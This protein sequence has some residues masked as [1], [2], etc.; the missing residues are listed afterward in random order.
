[1]VERQIKY[2]RVLMKVNI[3]IVFA[4][5]IIALIAILAT[6]IPFVTAGF[7]NQ[8]FGFNGNCINDGFND[9]CFC[10]E[11][12]DKIPVAQSFWEHRKWFCEE[13]ELFLDPDSPTFESDSI[14]YVKGYLQQNCG[15]TCN[16]LSCGGNICTGVTPTGQS[17][18]PCMNAV[19]GQLNTGERVVNVECVLVEEFTSDGTPKSGFIPWRMQFFVESVIENGDIPK[20]FE[21]QSN[22]C[23]D[24]TA[25]N[26]CEPPIDIIPS[27]P[28]LALQNLFQQSTT[29]DTFGS[30]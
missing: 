5:V 18:N 12:T 27:Y 19:W 2:M 1:M 14:A 15:D 28:S 23:V 9:N 21:F 26:R 30:R 25:T 8:V 24:T 29:V 6:D 7:L 20:A 13:S 3:G 22:Y 11:G 16:D 17:D 4:V 10:P